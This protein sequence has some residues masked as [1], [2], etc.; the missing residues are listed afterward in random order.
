MHETFA[1]CAQGSFSVESLE[2]F[3]LV[4]TLRN[5]Q[6]H[7]GGRVNDECSGA[8]SSLTPSAISLWEYLTKEIIPAYAIGDAVDLRQPQLIA[9]L[10]ITNRLMDEANS[11]LQTVVPVTRWAEM[12]IG[13]AIAEGID[14]VGNPDQRFRKLKAFARRYYGVIS[15]PDADLRTAAS[16]AGLVV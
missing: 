10:A 8:R 4:R 7:E 1:Q 13:D 12:A 5:S 16:A 3:H 11:M 2:L 15:V 6:I 14:L 9:C